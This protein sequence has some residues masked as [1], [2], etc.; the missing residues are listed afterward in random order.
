MEI[1]TTGMMEMVQRL[2][3]V[4]WGDF[5]IMERIKAARAE[6]FKINLSLAQTTAVCRQVFNY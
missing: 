2:N 1:A 4:D 3:G 5:E 6:C